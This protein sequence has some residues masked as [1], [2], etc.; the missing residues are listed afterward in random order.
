MRGSVTRHS[1]CKALIIFPGV[2]MATRL[3]RLWT[4]GLRLVTSSITQL[5]RRNQTI[6][7]DIS[8]GPY[9]C[10]GFQRLSSVK[11]GESCSRCR[12]GAGVIPPTPVLPYL[13]AQAKNRLGSRIHMHVPGISAPSRLLFAG[14]A[15]WA[16]I[17][18][19]FW[20]G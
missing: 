12:A 2:N 10:R 18:R 17:S 3:T 11:H 20:V 19:Q 16:H 9:C 5:P 1:Q 6:V 13:A 14:V 7:S 8:R 15:W 4:M